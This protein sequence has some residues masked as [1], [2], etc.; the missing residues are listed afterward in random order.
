LRLARGKRV[1]HDNLINLPPQI[2]EP[3][4]TIGAVERVGRSGEVITVLDQDALRR[5]LEGLRG[6]G[7]EAVAISYL[8]SFKNQGHEKRTAEI[9]H[10]ILGVPTFCGSELMP[11][12]REYERTTLTVLN[13]YCTKAFATLDTL[14]SRMSEAGLKTTVMLL[15]SSGGTI[16][17]DE[18]RSFPIALAESGPSA[19]VVAA[20]E[21]PKVADTQNL[22][23][24]DMGGTSFDVAVVQDG[25]PR[26]RRRGML[27]DTFTAVPVLDVDS[28]GSG[29][30]SIAWIDAIGVL[31]TGPRSAGSEPGPVCYGRGGLEATITDAMAVLGYIRPERFMGGT[32]KLDVEAARDAC[33]RLGKE[34]EWSAV[35]VARGIRAVALAQM[36]RAIRQKVAEAGSDIRD[37]YLLS[38]GG[39][40]SL[41]TAE[42]A[43]LV[44]A[45]GVIVSGMAST[46]SAYGASTAQVRRER[47]HAILA[48]F[49]PSDDVALEEVAKN[50]VAGIRED[51]AADQVDP[52]TG[53]YSLEFDLRFR[54]QA[55]EIPV[56]VDAG[57]ALTAETLEHVRQEYL[58]VYAERFGRASLSVRSE[59]EL[60]AVRAL[61]SPCEGSRRPRPWRS[62]AVSSTGTR[63]T[64]MRPVP[65]ER[66]SGRSDSPARSRAQFPSIRACT[67]QRGQTGP[68]RHG[69]CTAQSWRMVMSRASRA[70]GLRSLWHQ[71]RGST[72]APTPRAW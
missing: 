46:F 30:G 33:G 19:G 64:R 14:T 15:Q 60:V 18:A 65:G 20:A 49:P 39:S 25:V 68:P 62:S 70:A 23:C 27:L 36:A 51:L 40:G 58:R 22:I 2:V 9:V 43:R 28:I 4:L 37:Y 5:S 71:T 67:R 7:V 29:G 72:V 35:E 41:F 48:P 45:R 34:L 21:L 12:I 16:S 56:L 54:R 3:E 32:W 10:E 44:H 42:L 50:L 53:E 6:K 13:A 57:V 31:R 61:T 1:L 8:W 59:M 24:C 47:V 55:W 26:R 38:Y 52:D 66:S 11:V 17:I 63:W 69:D